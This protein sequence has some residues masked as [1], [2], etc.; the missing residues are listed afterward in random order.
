M[1]PLACWDCGFEF[2]RGHGCLCL[3]NVVCCQVEI[4]ATDRSLVQRSPTEFVCVIKCSSKF[5]HRQRVG[6]RGQT[7]KERK[8]ERKPLTLTVNIWLFCCKLRESNH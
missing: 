5:L 8:K 2:R 3:V 6:R 1:L 4:S 7:K